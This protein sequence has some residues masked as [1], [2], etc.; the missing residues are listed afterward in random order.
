MLKNGASKVYF[1][2]VLDNFLEEAI[3][4]LL[5]YINEDFLMICE[6]ARLRK[7]VKPGVFILLNSKN[8]LEKN[9]DL[10]SFADKIANLENIETIIDSLTLK[11]NSWHL[12]KL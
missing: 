1:I 2:Q 12:K 8:D 10:I 3:K 6:S 5:N 9:K 7:I 11:D 4:F